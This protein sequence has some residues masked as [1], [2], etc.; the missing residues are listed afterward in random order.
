MTEWEKLS[1][2]AKCTVRTDHTRLLEVGL[3]VYKARQKAFINENQGK[4]V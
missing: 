2:S 3:M 1:A 4:A